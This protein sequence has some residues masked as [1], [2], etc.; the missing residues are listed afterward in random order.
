[1]CSVLLVFCSYVTALLHVRCFFDI[2]SICTE[3]IPALRCYAYLLPVFV[4]MRSGI[5]VWQFVVQILTQERFRLKQL[6][7]T[8]MLTLK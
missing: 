3:A 7:S 4:E 5:K 2:Y 1:M 8:F 6:M